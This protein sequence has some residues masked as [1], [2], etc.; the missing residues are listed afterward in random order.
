MSDEE[1]PTWQEPTDRQKAGWGTWSRPLSPYDR[2]MEEQGIPVYRGIGVRQVRDLP[3]KPW[4]RMGGRG[5]FIQLHGTEG[6]WGMYVVEV[7]AAG[8]LNAERHLYEEIYFVVDGR[9][10]TEVWQEG[11]RPQIVEWSAGS[12]FAIPLNAHHRLVNA[13]NE[14]ALLLAATTAPNLINLIPG[15]NFVFGC[16]FRF[17]ERFD[18]DD[19]RYYQ[20]VDDL[21]PDP[22]RGLAMRR[23]NIIPDIVNGELPLDN[24]RSPGYRRVE[25]HMA[26]SNFY[27][28]CGQ[29]ETGRYSKAHR[30][31]SGAVLICVKGRG[32]TYTWPSELGTTPWRD[33]QGDLV[34][35]QDYEPVGMVS[36]APF[37]GDWFHQHFGIASEPLRLLVFAGPGHPFVRGRAPGVKDRDESSIDVK[38]GGRAI[39]YRDQDPHIEAEFRRMLDLQGATS[40]MSDDV[41][42]AEFDFVGGS[43]SPPGRSG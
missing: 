26:G 33:G 13:T 14:P 9:G 22:V 5:T 39:G 25:P 6:R 3:L 43:G 15:N 30:H 41:Y 36:A 10:T 23:T 2:F 12:L 35:R 37:S 28:F 7:P 20:P 34:Q 11:S 8:A 19:S 31:E 42:A 18:P 21:E 17:A 38:E 1:T 27:M 16:D 4:Q 40:G 29:H 24:R 32:Y